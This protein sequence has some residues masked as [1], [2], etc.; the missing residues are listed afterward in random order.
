MRVTLE[1]NKSK[2]RELMKNIVID[3]QQQINQQNMLLQR[4]LEELSLRKPRCIGL[5]AALPGEIDLSGIFLSED[6]VLAY[7]RVDGDVLTFHKV[8]S[9]N[10]LS[11]VP[12]YGICEPS[13]TAEIVI[14]DL[15]IV[16][17]I[18]FTKKGIRLGRGK[19]IMVPE[20]RTRNRF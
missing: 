3:S 10:E 18:A 7:P 11:P 19:G 12:P 8:K 6:T 16:P 15:I 17:G 20:N 5:F 13:M 4:L 14:P 1:M 2:L 9:L